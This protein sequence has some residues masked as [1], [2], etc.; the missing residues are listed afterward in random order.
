MSDREIVQVFNNR[1]DKVYGTFLTIPDLRLKPTGKTVLTFEERAEGSPQAVRAWFYPGD[2]YGH[3]FVYPK[4]QAMALAKANN[5]PVPSMP[6]ETD[7]TASN[8]TNT[9]KQTP[10]KAEKPN[11]EETEVTEEF[12]PPPPNAASSSPSSLPSSLPKTASDLPL[13]GLIGLLSLALAGSLRLVAVKWN[14]NER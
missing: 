7:T 11:Q 6:D 4:R 2:L 13:I 5:M 10:L 12:A 8:A 3:E 1:G 14:N 9:L